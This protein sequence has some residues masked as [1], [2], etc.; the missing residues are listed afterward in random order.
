MECC[1]EC[2]LDDQQPVTVELR[3]WNGLPIARFCATHWTETQLLA[4]GF[5]QILRDTSEIVAHPAA[6]APQI[7][8]G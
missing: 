7:T 8:Y 6:T 5:Q 1:L 2:P 3:D 4:D